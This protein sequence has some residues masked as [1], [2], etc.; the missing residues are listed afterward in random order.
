[1]FWRILLESLARRRSRKAL[2]CLTVWIGLSLVTALLGLGLDVGDKMSRELRSFG[3]NIRVMPAAAAIPLSVGG[4]QLAP[5]EAGAGLADRDLPRILQT[6]WRNNILGLVPRL[7]SRCRLGD[8]ECELVGVG[9]D[10][11]LPLEGGETFAT[12]ARKVYA[13][14]SVNGAWP[15]GPGECLVGAELARELALEVGG[16]IEV[17]AAAASGRLR[18][19]GI[20]ATGGPEDQAIIASLDEVQRLAGAAGRLS[21]IQVSALTTPENKLAEK[22]RLD[23]TKLTPAE[24]ERWVCTPYPGSVAAAIQGAVRGSSARVVRRI[25]E[26]EGTV[27]SRIDG[28]MVVLGALTLIACGFAVMGVLSSAVL[29]RRPEVALLQAL[30]AHRADVLMLFLVEIGLLG[31]AGGALSAF[32]GG[33]VGQWLVREVFG[34]TADVH[35][36]LAILSPFLG[37]ALSLAAGAWPVWQ[38]LH[39]ETAQVLTGN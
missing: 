36:S 27:L 1:M 13:H 37:L 3:A 28:L 32:T 33:L 39:Q 12:G 38:A 24:Y 2:A 8:R 14:W 9:L 16:E 25:A 22:Y 35:L 31:L 10:V 15:A 30:G 11:R 26:A 20:V 7:T 23:P 21:E 17:V 34:A 18:V 5:A 29:D 19:S 6:F 4:H